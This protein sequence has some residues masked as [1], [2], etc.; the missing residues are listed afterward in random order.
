MTFQSGHDS[1]VGVSFC[2][3]F[4]A[5]FGLDT[6]TCAEGGAVLSVDLVGIPDVGDPFTVVISE[7]VRS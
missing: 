2:P 6:P 4:I 3:S 1:P 5:R 7:T